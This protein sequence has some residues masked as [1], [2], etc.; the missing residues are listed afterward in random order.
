MNFEKI[1]E[2]NKNPQNEYDVFENFGKS[3]INKRKVHSKINPNLRKK[4]EN[5][6][7]V[8][9]ENKLTTRAIQE[10]KTDKTIKSSNLSENVYSTVKK[11]VELQKE[12]LGKDTSSSNLINQLRDLGIQCAGIGP[13]YEIERKESDNKSTAPWEKQTQARI[14][15]RIHFNTQKDPLKPYIYDS[16][17]SY[18]SYD[19]YDSGSYPLPTTGSIDFQDP[20]LNLGVYHLEWNERESKY[21]IKNC[22]ADDKKKDHEYQKKAVFLKNDDQFYLLTDVE[23]V[24]VREEKIKGAVKN[25]QNLIDPFIKEIEPFIN[26]DFFDSPQLLSKCFESGVDVR[27]LGFFLHNL[28]FCPGGSAESLYSS[29]KGIEFRKSLKKLSDLVINPNHSC[30][31]EIAGRFLQKLDGGLHQKGIQLQMQIQAGEIKHNFLVGVKNLIEVLVEGKK[32]QNF[33]LLYKLKSQALKKEH[34]TKLNGN[35]CFNSFF[36]YCSQIGLEITEKAKNKIRNTSPIKSEYFEKFRENLEKT[37]TVD[38]SFP[39]VSGLGRTVIVKGGFVTVN[40]EMIQQIQEEAR[41][42]KIDW[43]EIKAV[44]FCSGSHIALNT[45][46][47]NRDF[48]G[49]NVVF[50]AQKELYVCKNATIDVS[51][52]DGKEGAFGKHSGRVGVNANQCKPETPK[53]S[54][55]K[56]VN[57][58]LGG[59]GGTGSDGE[60]GASG[61]HVGTSIFIVKN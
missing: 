58:D 28:G 7:C 40:D 36:N 5:E 8:V 51:G 37:L 12:Y 18:D 19:G 9:I 35:E 24:S 32:K 34:Y 55:A 54:G 6:K 42:Q 52:L 26:P 10:I 31:Q 17:D 39:T 43:N 13:E 2:S 57:G 15:A 44:H 47:N 25:M 38:I 20:E 30:H 41:K 45:S 1:N 46:F 33:P 16:Y 29:E 11:I 23:V 49:K 56:G 21:E 50:H 14:Q 60:D 48:S 59:Q 22:S 4:N 61:T 27:K 3:N 53:I